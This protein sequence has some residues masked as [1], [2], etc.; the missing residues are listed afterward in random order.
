MTILKREPFFICNIN[1]MAKAE[2]VEGYTFEVE[3]HDGMKWPL[4]TNK[5][6]HG[7]WHLTDILTGLHVA[8]PTRTRLECVELA[9]S[10]RMKEKMWSYYDGNTELYLAKSEVFQMLVAGK[11]MTHGEYIVAVNEIEAMKREEHRY[12]EEDPATEVATETAVVTLEAMREKGWPD[13][14]VRQRNEGACIWVVGALEGYEEELAEMGFR[15][16]RS[17]HYGEG[18]WMRPQEA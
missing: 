4:G 14:L 11:R 3:V 1:D 12:E 17:K 18:W 6:G 8:G 5:D 7:H 9:E 16:G 15:P 2:K 10:E 13:V